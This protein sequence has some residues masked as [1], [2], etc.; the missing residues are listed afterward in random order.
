M[1]IV[2]AVIGAGFASG[3]EV[4]SFFGDKP[5]AFVALFCALAV[6][7]SSV[8]FLF[9]GRRLIC[10]NVGDAH[11][12]MFGKLRPVADI[13]ILFNSL[14]VLGAMISGMNSV[15]AEFLDIKIYGA[16]AAVICLIL[17]VKQNNVVRVNAILVPIMIV[18]IAV[19]CILGIDFPLK[20][21]NVMRFMPVV[22]YVCMNMLLGGAVMTTVHNLSKREIVLSAALASLVIGAL[23]FCITGALAT[24]DASYA[25][26]PMIVIAL[27]THPACYYVMLPVL[28]LS[29]FTTMVVAFR[30]LFDYL[31]SFVKSPFWCALIVLVCGYSV[32]LLG[33]SRVV[34]KLYPVT[35]VIGAVYLISTLIYLMKQPIKDALARKKQKV[36]RVKRKAAKKVKSKIRAVVKR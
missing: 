6:F 3:K 31:H 9:A 27:K 14:T 22:L 34:D 17:T 18:A 13:F 23:L 26:M 2:G 21:Q 32:S 15:G 10:D 29:I 8:V 35:G 12:K 28:A 5:S 4:V 30:S 16:L 36:V 20:A 33:F 7:G 24:A 11:E 1:M 19:T 25:D